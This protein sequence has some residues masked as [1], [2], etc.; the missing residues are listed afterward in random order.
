M[1]TFSYNHPNMAE[2]THNVSILLYADDIVLLS[3]NEN[4]L[5]QMLD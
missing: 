5:Q 3:E 4:H 2:L 1:L